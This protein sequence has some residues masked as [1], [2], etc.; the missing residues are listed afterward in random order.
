[1]VDGTWFRVT[2]TDDMTSTVVPLSQLEIYRIR[3]RIRGVRIIVWWK[4]DVWWPILDRWDTWRGRG[5]DN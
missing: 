2:A 4:H 5:L 1:M 3:M